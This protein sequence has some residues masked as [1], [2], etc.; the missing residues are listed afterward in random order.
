MVSDRVVLQVGGDLTSSGG[1]A[2]N[3]RSRSDQ[4]AQLSWQFCSS[5]QGPVCSA[6]STIDHGVV[7]QGREQLQR[8]GR[9]V[10]GSQA[11]GGD[12]RTCLGSGPAP[13]A[14]ARRLQV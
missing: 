7:G 2:G 6:S 5:A 9:V 14:A 12:L 10:I 8:G 4:R 13:P 3:R 1:Q 11:Q